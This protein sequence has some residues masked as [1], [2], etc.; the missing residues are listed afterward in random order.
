MKNVQGGVGDEQKVLISLFHSPYFG[1]SGSHVRADKI[2]QN[3][4]TSLPYIWFTK[5]NWNFFSVWNLFI[6]NKYKNVCT[7]IWIK[8]NPHVYVTDIDAKTL[9]R[10][11]IKWFK[12]E[13]NTMFTISGKL[14]VFCTCHRSLFA[15]P[16]LIYIIQKN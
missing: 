2:F 8:S 6:K 9:M 16:F 10:W 4:R 15:V 11:T 1:M 5:P 7:T 14:H 13:A 3:S 12:K